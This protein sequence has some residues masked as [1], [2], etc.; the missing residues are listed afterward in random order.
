VQYLSE[1]Q[2]GGNGVRYENVVA[3]VD[4][5]VTKPGYGILSEC[6][7]TCTPMLYTS[8]GAFREYDLLVSH[9]PR[10]VRSRFITREDLLAGRWREGLHALLEQPAPPE[11]MEAHGADVAADL[12]GGCL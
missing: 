12:I 11:R 8:R 3:A 7:S 4:A 9:M 10:V 2:L 6:V 5:V 1:T